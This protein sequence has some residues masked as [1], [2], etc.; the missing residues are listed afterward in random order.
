MGSKI[1]K[2]QIIFFFSYGIALNILNII[3]RCMP[4]LTN[5]EK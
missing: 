4:T 2:N 3:F 5:F 1:I